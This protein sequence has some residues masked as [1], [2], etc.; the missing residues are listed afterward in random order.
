MMSVILLW[1]LGATLSH[2]KEVPFKASEKFELVTKYDFRIRPE[3]RDEV[4]WGTR[5]RAAT[6]PRP[7][8]EITLKVLSLDSA[9]SRIRVSSNFNTGL[10]NRRVD[11]GDSFVI[12]LGFTDDMKDRTSAHR[13]LVEFLTEN[14]KS[15]ISCIV[16]QIEED[17]RFM[18]N[19]EQRGKL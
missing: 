14:K 4:D 12:D 15:T 6:S 8:L 9:E 13:Y 7:Y 11:A 17:G 10:I 19:G 1:L 2:Q 5:K 3:R 16:I 18:V